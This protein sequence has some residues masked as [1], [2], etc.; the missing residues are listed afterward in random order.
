MNNKYLVEV[1]GEYDYMAPWTNDKEPKSMGEEFEEL[2]SYLKKSNVGHLIE[3]SFID[4]KKDGL[5]QTGHSDV[6]TLMA[7]GKLPPIVKVNNMPV[8]YNKFQKDIVLEMVNFL[9]EED[10]K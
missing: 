6:W 8:T 4:I 9:I 3:V 7:K 5:D 2:K 10:N 1:I